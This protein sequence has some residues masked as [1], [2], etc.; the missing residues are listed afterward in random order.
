MD[1]ALLHHPFVVHRKIDVDEYHRMAEAGILVPDDRVELIEGELIAMAPI[2]ERHVGDSIGL[3]MRLV[4]AVGDLALVSVGNPVRL[5][6]Y[7]EP[8]PDFTLLRPRADSY[9]GH[10]PLPEDV[11]LAIELSES[12]LRFDRTV[13]LPLYGAHGIGE[14]WIFD[15]QARQVSVCRG[16][17]ADGYAS[18]ETH[19]PDATIE[20]EALPGL[21]FRVA[22]L[23]P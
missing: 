21:A 1:G 15:L 19:G 8:Q 3:N 11:L 6:R 23:L 22:D 7:S 13:K 9:R 5:G 17:C 20:A 16:P 10:K 2:G 14:F 18:V 12:S 4:R